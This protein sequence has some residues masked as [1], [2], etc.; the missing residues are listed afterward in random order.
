MNKI[1]PYLIAIPLVALALLP[2][3]NYWIWAVL[4]S[5]C[6]GF[7]TL[8]IKVDLFIK[9]FSVF[10]FLNCFFSAAPHISFSNYIW[11][12]GFVYFYIL[13]TKIKNW[14][15][16]YNILL[17]VFILQLFLVCV[18]VL[19]IDALMNFGRKSNIIYGSVGNSMQ[20]KSL[21]I[22]IGAFLIAYR[23]PRRLKL[24]IISLV[25][26]VLIYAI[27]CRVIYWF[28]LVRGPAWQEALRLSFQ[29]PFLGWGIGTFKEIFP[30]LGKGVF[31][32]EG[33]WRNLHNDW[34]QLFFETGLLGITLIAGFILSLIIK[35][36]RTDNIHCLVG[37]VMIMASMCYYFPLNQP[38]CI[39]I[40]IMF[41]A[42]MKSQ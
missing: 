2:P 21:L 35:L 16:I 12:A 39:L 32:Q 14:K 11:F 9:I 18:Q 4:L 36:L 42:Y 30:A 40:M 27:L 25:S 41:L 38:H 19:N 13:C 3:N 26:V 8:F 29:H 17:T 15:P 20:L 31:A 24:I 22:V 28:P 34:L 5:A 23:K 1:L 10:A 7:Y 37:L 33:I 6:L